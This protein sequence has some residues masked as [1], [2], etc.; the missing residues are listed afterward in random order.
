MRAAHAAHAGRDRV[1]AAL[2][3]DDLAADLVDWDNDDDLDDLDAYIADA[4]R[5]TG[6]PCIDDNRDDVEAWTPPHAW[7]AAGLCRE[8]AA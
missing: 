5:R 8:V 2:D 1:T 7:A 4:E 3:L 6:D